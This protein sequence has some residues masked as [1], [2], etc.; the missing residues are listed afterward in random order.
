[1]SRASK[2]SR[3]SSAIS[4]CLSQYSRMVGFSPRLQRARKSSASSSTGLRSSLEEDMALLPVL[5]KEPRGG[6]EHAAQALQRSN[7]PIAGGRGLDAEHLRGLVVG[8]FLEMP[9][10]QDLPVDRVQ[11]VDGLLEDE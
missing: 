6:L 5:V 11:G 10:G 2:T 1:M 9:E 8:E 3:I 4:G 7:M